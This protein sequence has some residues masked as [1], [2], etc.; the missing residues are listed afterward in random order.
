M[1]RPR[2]PAGSARATGHSLTR[3]HQ[4]TSASMGGFR[5]RGLRMMI[6]GLGLL[7]GLAGV[8]AAARLSSRAV[9]LP[10]GHDAYVTDVHLP[11]K[12]RPFSRVVGDGDEFHYDYS[13]NS[14]GF[15]DV[16]HAVVK[17]K[18]T[19]RLLGLGD[20]FTYGVGVTFEETYLYRLEA[21]LN[22]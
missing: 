16:E 8:E 7:V 14:L 12:P 3:R 19:F 11:F 2:K 21:M 9:P 22:N 15:R 4:L 17:G 18:A 13:H 1:T 5:G 20:S 6:V 10:E